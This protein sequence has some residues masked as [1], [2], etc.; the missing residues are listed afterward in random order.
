MSVL[1]LFDRC[2]RSLLITVAAIYILLALYFSVGRFLLPYIESLVPTLVSSLEERTGLAWTIE[3]L[4]GEWNKLNPVLRVGKLEARLAITQSPPL[5]ASDALDLT[6]NKIVFSLSEGELRLDVLASLF[7]R[8]FRLTDIQGKNLSVALEKTVDKHWKIQG[9]SL[10]GS[11][12]SIALQG[13]LSHIRRLA[14]DNI[15][16]QWAVD[17]DKMVDIQLPAM[18]MHSERYDSFRR[19]TFSQT[20]QDYGSFKLLVETE[21]APFSKQANINAYVKADHFSL[22]PWLELFADQWVINDWSGEFWATKKPDRKW[23]ATAIVDG[24]SISRAGSFNWQIEEISVRLGVEEMDSG[25]V[26]LWWQ[27]LGATWRKQPLHMPLAHISLAQ[28]E[29]KISN[30]IIRTPVVNIGQLSEILADSGVLS[31]P[32][33]KVLETL[34]PGGMVKQLHVSIPSG[35]RITE[36]S[37]EALLE[38]VSVRPWGNI[39]GG[40]G[41]DGYIHANASRGL[42]ALSVDD[43][44]SIS[45]PQIYKDP[46]V[47]DKAEGLVDWSIGKRIIINGKDIKLQEKLVENKNKNESDGGSSTVIDDDGTSDK[48]VASSAVAGSIGGS[49][50]VDVGRGKGSEAGHMEL[51][52]GVKNA[53]G[54]SLLHLIPFTVNKGLQ[55]WVADA[56]VQAQV[57]DGAFIYNGSLRKNEGERRSIQLYFNLSEA[58]V[59]F[60]RNWPKATDIDGL[61]EISS[62]QT[63]VNVIT[64]DLSGLSIKNANV[65]VHTAERDARVELEANVGGNLDDVFS[66]LQHSPLQQQ[67]GELMGTWRGAGKVKDGRLSLSIPLDEQYVDNIRVDFSGWIED[68]I[69]DMKNLDIEVTDVNGPIS[70]TTKAGLVS[71]KITAKIW[72]EPVEVVLGDYT[73][74]SN[75][76]GDDTFRVDV[77]GRVLAKD[78]YG[79]LDQP[80]F[81]FAEGQSEIDLRVDYTRSQ[82]LLSVNSDLVGIT[83]ALPGELSKHKD[84]A[85]ALNLNWDIAA[86]RQPMLVE[87]AERAKIQLEFE[88][89][90][91][92]GGKVLVGQRAL[93]EHTDKNIFYNNAEVGVGQKKVHEKLIAQYKKQTIGLAVSGHLEHFNLDEWLEVLDQYERAEMELQNS[94]VAVSTETEIIIRRLRL[95]DLNAFDMPFSNAVVEALRVEDRWQFSIESDQVK[96]LV[97]LPAKDSKT[98]VVADVKSGVGGVVRKITND[99]ATVKENSVWDSMPLIL[100]D[101]AERDRFKLDLVYLRLNKPSLLDGSSSFLPSSLPSPS[102]LVP[103]DIDI[104]QLYI[105]KKAVGQWSFL[106]TPT[107]NIALIHNVIASYA[108]MDIRSTIDDGLLWGVSNKGE[109]ASSLDISMSSNNIAA[110]IES[111]AASADANSPIKSKKTQFELALNWSGGPENFSLKTVSGEFEFAFSKGQFLKASDS[112][113]GLLKAVSLVNFD[114]LLRRLQLDFSDLYKDGLSF[115]SVT[116][117]LQIEDELAHFDQVPIKIKSPSSQF[118]LT[119]HVDL[120]EA[121]IDAELVMTLPVASNLPWI[122]ALAGGLPVAAGVFI[123]SKL[124]SNE[125]DRL[126]SAVYTI[127]GPL[128]NAEAKFS[129]LFDAGTDGG[130]DHTAPIQDIGESNE[131]E[132]P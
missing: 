93:S 63:Q 37:L 82:T 84:T 70:F 90:K 121:S 11:G 107:N 71:N 132:S 76:Q 55:R 4:S 67:L 122:A 36:F 41:I 58:E 87:I 24:G 81:V 105:G 114:T 73:G 40:T 47:F 99:D 115:D 1:K 80:L 21:N 109:V 38:N 8:E 65:V 10:S 5:N 7:S 123:A 61:V 13:F 118:S 110:F 46:L 60:D 88:Q 56:E 129:R 3:G 97:T 116:G 23:Q 27:E 31:G 113:Q 66:V 59:R 57:I 54:S 39:P 117:T 14:I 20:S 77:N 29:A 9:M 94:G 50:F 32:P 108:S 75:K 44:F 26:D 43:G 102:E 92:Y 79:W 127:K 95:D 19:F 72:G 30:I 25:G 33:L 28:T 85:A 111:F 18:Q 126:S 15:N 91:F 74:E 17:G 104:Q 131:L 103:L 49:F 2:L 96:G 86:V 42:I 34:M 106:L 119:G 78:I 130:G 120:D 16:L 52:I 48:L 12:Q 53:V 101:L 69:I 6:N 51:N 98:W 22:T 64:G 68:G 100:D 112:A 35:K 62:S 83:L 124:F 45:F 125:L 128:D 89:F